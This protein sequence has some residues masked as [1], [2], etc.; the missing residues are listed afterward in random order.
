MGL[1]EK[2]EIFVQAQAARDAAEAEVVKE[3]QG[4]EIETAMIPKLEVVVH[5]A[6]AGT[7]TPTAWLDT[8]VVVST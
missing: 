7:D 6:D 8:E 5:L 2:V 3:M 1:A 4:L